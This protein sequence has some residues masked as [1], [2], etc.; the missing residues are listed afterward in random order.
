MNINRKALENFLKLTS[1]RINN[2]L[3]TSSW[4]QARLLSSC[5]NNCVRFFKSNLG[6]IIGYI[7]WATVTRET[8]NM[9]FK[10]KHLPFYAYE[11]SDGRIMFIYDVVFDSSWIEQASDEA[12][13]FLLKK[14]FFVHAKNRKINVYAKVDGEIVCVNKR[15]ANFLGC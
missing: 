14:R 6:G 3:D 9:C 8:L 15:Y 7:A 5:E 13:I 10:K 2:N 12:F 4:L 11:Y 1:F